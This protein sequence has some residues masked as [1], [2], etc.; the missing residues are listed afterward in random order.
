VSFVSRWF[1]RDCLIDGTPLAHTSYVLSLE[2]VFSP[3]QFG[4]LTVR[5][6]AHSRRDHGKALLQKDQEMKNPQSPT[7]LRQRFLAAG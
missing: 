7:N 4:L 1:W 3:Y 6:Q 2:D 5:L